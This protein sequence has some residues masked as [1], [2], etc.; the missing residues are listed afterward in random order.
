MKKIIS[1]LLS[2][3]LVSATAI[4]ANATGY[5]KDYK[6]FCDLSKTIVLQDNT[7]ALFSS[8][9]DYS[10]NTFGMRFFGKN[11]AVLDGVFKDTQNGA[12]TFYCTPGEI[13]RRAMS[14]GIGNST[15]GRYRYNFDKTGGTY[16]K[17]RI[18]LSVF[19]NYFNADGSC[20]KELGTSSGI[21]HDYKFKYEDLGDRNFC[22][23][24]L[25]MISG[26]AYTAVTPDRNG[27]VEFYVCTDIGT[28]TEYI[29]E[30]E[31]RRNGTRGGGGGKT[32][33]Y[34]RELTFGDV[35]GSEGVDVDD[36]T[37]LQMFIAE[38]GDVDDL[39]YFHSDTNCD[40]VIDVEDVTYLQF[41]IAGVV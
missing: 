20:T 13:Y 8:E 27:D 24:S 40:G 26:G 15:D 32:G 28:V 11:G 1:V 36:V 30:F 2:A 31:Y 37:K 21:Y 9:I 22:N 17:V 23:S 6:G 16:K 29:T 7:V 19:D 35:D 39:G 33:V 41:G 12:K 25:V 4:S 10:T 5:V 34:I 18:N 14:N 38:L 3:V